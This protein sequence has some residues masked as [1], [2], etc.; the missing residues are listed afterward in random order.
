MAR[1]VWFNDTLSPG[2]AGFVTALNK[3]FEDELDRF[4]ELCQG[5]M[6]ENAS[7]EDRTGDAREGLVSEFYKTGNEMGIVLAHTVDYGIWLEV[8]WSGRYAIII[9]TLEVMGPAMMA[10]LTGIIDRADDGL[11]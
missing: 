8:R 4:A 2:M 9:P 6:Q 10:S 3:Q 5:Y 7:W 11:T 1:I